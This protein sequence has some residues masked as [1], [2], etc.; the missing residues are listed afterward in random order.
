MTNYCGRFA[1]TPSGPLHLGSL[2]AAVGSYLDARAHNGQWL[3]RI[4][5]VDQPRAVPGAD[6]EILAQLHAHGLHWDG[7]V[8]Y[9]SQRSERYHQ[10]LEQLTAADKTYPCSC[11]RK[12]IK[13][14]GPFYTGYCRTHAPAEGAKVAIRFKNDKPVQQFTDLA[15]GVVD[16]EAA[17]AQ[18]DFVLKRRDQLF[19]YQLAVVV[20]DIDQQ[21]SHIV[22]G[23]DLL[24]ASAWQLTLWRELGQP[25]PQLRHLPLVVDA[26]GNKLSK[27]NHAPSL[28]ADKIPEQL[29]QSF[30]YL[31]LPAAP[32]R[33]NTAP[34]L[35]AWAIEAWQKS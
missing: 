28:S 20:D 22:R 24:T 33:L 19:A 3:V 29:R 27:Q 5:D 32:A 30:A 11:T 15:H 16:I 26:N 25:L 34:G 35:L 14:R 13:A 12:Q 4:E 18:E 7:D 9:Q 8:L 2:V 10:I 23:S 6:V 17:F 1:P 31:Q 21:V